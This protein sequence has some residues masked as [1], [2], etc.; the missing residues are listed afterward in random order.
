MAMLIAGWF[1]AGASERGASARREKKRGVSGRGERA[2]RHVSNKARQHQENP[3]D[4]R[5]EPWSLQIN[6][7][8]T[9]RPQRAAK[10]V[11]IASTRTPEYQQAD[12][13]G[14]QEQ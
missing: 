8:E 9:L 4:H 3:A 1:S 2:P 7:P 13:R 6:G 11:K 5:G 12:G 14:A 10:T